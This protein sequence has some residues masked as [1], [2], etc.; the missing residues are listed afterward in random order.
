[1]THDEILSPYASPVAKIGI[2][3]HDRVKTPTR[4]SETPK[5]LVKSC[6]NLRPQRTVQCTRYRTE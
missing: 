1:M 6:A 4:V 5:P 2:F 3:S